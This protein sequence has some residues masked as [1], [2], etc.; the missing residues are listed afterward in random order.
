MCRKTKF[1]DSACECHLK[2]MTR[3]EMIEK[4]CHNVARCGCYVEW[5]YEVQNLVSCQLQG[6]SEHI[7]RHANKCQFKELFE[8]YKNNEI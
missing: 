7:E 1:V 6:V 4:F 2:R 3:V 8:K 5:S